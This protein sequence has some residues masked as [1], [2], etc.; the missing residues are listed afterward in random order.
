V[1]ILDALDPL[2]DEELQAA[3]DALTDAL[4]ALSSDAV[5]HRR[6]LTHPDRTDGGPPC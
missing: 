1:F 2:T 5:I 4:L 3:A 6:L